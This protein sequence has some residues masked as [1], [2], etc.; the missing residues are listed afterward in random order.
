MTERKVNRWHHFPSNANYTLHNDGTVT[1]SRNFV[2]L[3]RS[4]DDPESEKIWQCSG[5]YDSLWVS[6]KSGSMKIEDWG[7]KN[8]NVYILKTI[9][10]FNEILINDKE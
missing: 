7:I 6:L 4:K 5:Y 3:E 8:Q 1:I 10:D 2:L 9:D